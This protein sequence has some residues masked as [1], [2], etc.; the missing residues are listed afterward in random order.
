MADNTIK[1]VLFEYELGH[2]LHIDVQGGAISFDLSK[3]EIYLTRMSVKP[4][5]EI[6]RVEIR[7]H[8][9]NGT[10]KT[11]A[12][13]VGKILN[14]VAKASPTRETTKSSKTILTANELANANRDVEK[15]KHEEPKKVNEAALPD[16]SI[17]VITD[18][19][20]VPS[21]VN[22]DDDTF[23]IVT[24]AESMTKFITFRQSKKI[25]VF[26]NGR[27]FTPMDEI[28]FIKRVLPQINMTVFI[29]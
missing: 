2:Q 26:I 19:L 10:E 23:N 16:M 7:A 1:S 8:Y 21:Q 27:E 20:D 12:E 9:P 29:K 24:T 3:Q 13:A 4:A 14:V 28:E 15:A 6:T 5:V 22:V 11:I 25:K 18:M 17:E